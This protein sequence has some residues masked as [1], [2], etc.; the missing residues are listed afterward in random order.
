MLVWPLPRLPGA[1]A[2]ILLASSTAFAQLAPQSQAEFEQRFTGWTMLAEGP[3]CDDGNG[4]AVGTVTFAGQGQ[5]GTGLFRGTYEYEGTG[6]N[7]G[8]LTVKLNILPDA[9][10]MSLTFNSRTMGTFTATVSGMACEGSFEI[11]E[12]TEDTTAP[13]LVSVEVDTSGD[14]V[15][16]TF[17]EGMELTYNPD[18][19]DNTISITADD[20]T[21]ESG[22][23]LIRD[24]V[25]SLQNLRPIITRGQEV[26]VAYE[27]PTP[28]DDDWGLS[29]DAGN[30]SPSF[31]VTAVNNSAVAG[32]PA[33][34]LAALGLLALLLMGLGS[35][36]QRRSG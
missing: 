30:D 23:L 9:Q 24:H 36:H 18:G 20:Q 4:L 10:V 33:L 6:A 8:T 11:V 3:D 25:I 28:G 15:D 12:S 2:G 13:S 29:D 7:T 1:W 17:D 32:A 31:M 19:S 34:P 35:A 16:F 14:A 21:V 26:I 5:F 22:F 27:D